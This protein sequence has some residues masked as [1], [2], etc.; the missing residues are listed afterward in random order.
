MIAGKHWPAAWMSEKDF[1][2]HVESIAHGYGWMTSHAHLPFFDTAGTPDLLIVHPKTGRTIFAELKVRGKTGNL[3]K[4]TPAQYRWLAALG[5]KN[6][7]YIWSW[8][9]DDETIY[10]KMGGQQ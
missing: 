2:A 9:D 5:I 1:Q 10:E 8:P 3:P 7:T 4:P 6:E